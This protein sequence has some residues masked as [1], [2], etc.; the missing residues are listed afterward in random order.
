M[1]TTEQDPFTADPKAPAIQLY[2]DALGVLT[3]LLM[4]YYNANSVDAGNRAQAWLEQIT[5]LGF[6]EAA[7]LIRDDERDCT[8]VAAAVLSTDPDH[9]GA[10]PTPRDVKAG[11]DVIAHLLDNQL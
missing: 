5:R 7:V 11:A 10:P 6:K 4:A 3:R 9:N 2:E 1:T 8:R